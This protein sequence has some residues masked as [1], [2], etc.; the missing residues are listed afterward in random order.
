MAPQV[1]GQHCVLCLVSR[2]RPHSVHSPQQPTR[3]SHTIHTHTNARARAR[4]HTHTHTHT[5]TNAR[6]HAR[7][8]THTHTHT[9]NLETSSHRM[10][11][12]LLEAR[13][14]TTVCTCV[15][16]NP[17]DTEIFQTRWALDSASRITCS[18]YIAIIVMAA[19][20]H[21]HAY[22]HMHVCKHVH[23]VTIANVSAVRVHCTER[24]VN[25]LLTLVTVTGKD[26]RPTPI[27]KDT[28]CTSARAHTHTHTHTHIHTHTH[29]QIALTKA[30]TQITKR[31]QA[32]SLAVPPPYPASVVAYIELFPQEVGQE[33]HV[34]CH[35][36]RN[37][38][39]RYCCQDQEIKLKNLQVHHLHQPA[40]Y[41]KLAVDWEW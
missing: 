36:M 6:T 17:V 12:C 25:S 20:I 26:F 16:P 8:H 23:M 5:H 30:C 31:E 3:T 13:R 4:T 27:P 35:Q 41:Q 11:Q 39:G 21:V 34:R 33:Q 32:H 19:Q 29:T 1:I 2:I 37:L 28:T 22:R 14:W 40:D 15:S 9:L 24:A 38:H 10:M 7:T 18:A